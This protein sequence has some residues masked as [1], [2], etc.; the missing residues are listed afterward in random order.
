MRDALPAVTLRDVAERAGVSIT[1]VSRILNG[2]ETG[3]V[4]REETRARIV[5]AAADLGY[6][7][8]LHARALRGSRSSLL[9][10]IVRDISDPFHTQVLR[11]VNEIARDRGYRLFLGHLD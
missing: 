6:K 8:N 7:P 2:R 10:V 5:A 3:V 4:I 1:T 11:G 9:G